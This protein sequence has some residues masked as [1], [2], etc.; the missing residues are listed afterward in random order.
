[1]RLTRREKEATL[2]AVNHMLAGGAQDLADALGMALDAA[3]HMV[4]RLERVA[5][6][7][8]ADI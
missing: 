6:K 1:M 4:A 3:E 8:K 2:D 5:E 7:L